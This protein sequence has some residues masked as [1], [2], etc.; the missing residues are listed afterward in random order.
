MKIAVIDNFDS[1]VFNLVRY[2]KES[3]S[4]E[5]IIQRNNQ[6]D[7]SILDNCDAI[8]LSPGPGIPSEAGELIPI[9][10]KYSGKKKMLGICLGHQAIAEAFGGKLEQCS[11]PLHGKSSIVNQIIEDA[12]FTGISKNFQ[13]G[14]YHSWKVKNDLPNDLITTVISEENEI[15]ALKHKTHDTKGL[16]FHPESILT[17]DGRKMIENWINEIN[18]SY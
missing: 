7:Y 5:I 3:T 10:K 14:R 9:I 6:I 8:L 13:V 17:P 1:F 15:M 16:Q 12:L 18:S 4:S 2:L 11:S